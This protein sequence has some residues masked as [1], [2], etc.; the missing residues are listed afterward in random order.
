MKTDL[1][2]ALTDLLH[3]KINSLNVYGEIS[4]DDSHIEFNVHPSS[5]VN[6][7]QFLPLSSAIALPSISLERVYYTFE[8]S[9]LVVATHDYGSQ[10]IIP[11]ILELQNIALSFSVGLQNMS[12]LVITFD[13]NFVLGG[14]VIPVEA[15]YTHA[16]RNI[17]ISAK[18]SG[19]FINFQS[20]A[21]E[22]VGL[23]LP[24]ALQQPI[25]I[26]TIIA[27]VWKGNNGRE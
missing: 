22:L 12:T 7:F 9:N 11:L 4:L 5:T 19:L 3:D 23:N 13:G 21:T 17:N 25:S 16:S 10:S 27:N 8:T 20:V 1:K 2:S 15:I 14:V 6:L 24:G 18:V 26:P